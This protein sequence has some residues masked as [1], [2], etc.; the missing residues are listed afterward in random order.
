MRPATLRPAVEGE[1]ISVEQDLEVMHLAGYFQ[2]SAERVRLAI[3]EAGPLLADVETE[4]RQ[5]P[6]IQ[7]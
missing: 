3:Q 7:L 2:V 6:T 4:L 5:H 1:Q